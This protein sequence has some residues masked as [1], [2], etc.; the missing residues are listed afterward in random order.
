MTGS[1]MEIGSY[2]MPLRS[3]SRGRDGVLD[4]YG[5]FVAVDSIAVLASRSTAAAVHFARS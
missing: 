2:R 1:G 5:S 3:T 4:G